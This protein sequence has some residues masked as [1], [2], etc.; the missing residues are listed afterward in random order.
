[1]RYNIVTL[2]EKPELAEQI[3]LL[4][5][6]AWPKF[7]L[8]ANTLH[9]NSLYTTFTEFQ[10]VLC[11]LYGNVIAVGHTIPLVWDG[12]PASLPMNFDDLLERA[13]ICHQ[14]GHN[15]TTLSALGAV[16]APSHRRQ[17]LSGAIL[18][19]MIK[20]ATQRRLNDLIAPVRPTMKDQYPL[21]PIER[22]VEWKRPDGSPFDFW[23]RVHWRLGGVQLQV[24]PEAMR[25][26]G[27][28]AEWE[29]WTGMEFP[30][31][32]R[33]VVP[34]A[35]QPVSIDRDKDYGLYCDPNVWVRHPISKID[36]GNPNTQAER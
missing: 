27:S 33:Y 21:I 22:Y 4:N 2:Q 7:L 11:D 3:L 20:L 16:V 26:Q 14:R 28:V 8:H 9:W 10:L 34:G 12:N 18:R 31:S 24:A 15:A 35:L 36:T 32:G 25:V 19:E 17:G 30:E 23:L 5:R 29:E 1:M 13:I 6:A